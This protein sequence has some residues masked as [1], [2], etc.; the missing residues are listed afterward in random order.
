M[1][2]ASYGWLPPLRGENQGKAEMMCTHHHPQTALTP[3][4]SLSPLLSSLAI[5]MGGQVSPFGESFNER[6]SPASFG[7]WL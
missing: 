6:L 1:C 3:A 5:H 2:I 7:L 4:S